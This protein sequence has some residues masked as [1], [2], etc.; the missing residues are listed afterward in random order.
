MDTSK[1]DRIQSLWK[2]CKK[3]GLHETRN[4]VVFWRGHP[5]ARLAIIGEAPGEMEDRRG[6][7][8][9][10]KAGQ[11]FDE[12]CAKAIVGSVPP[13]PWNVFIANVIGCRPPKNRK[14]TVNE[15]LACEARLYAMIAAVDPKVLLLLGGTA[16]M[17]LTGDAEIMKR[18]G[19]VVDVEFE[20]RRRPHIYKAVPTLHPG[21][22]LRN[23]NNSGVMNAVVTHIR[24][25]WMM[26]QPGGWLEGE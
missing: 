14:P 8:F 18:A 16:L 22:L 10:G 7:P 2:D 13:E 6:K 21:F 20:W 3:C 1:L 11:L 17:M 24:T 15:F 19:S 5:Q 26:A 12:L 4:Q 9:L 23:K 25:A